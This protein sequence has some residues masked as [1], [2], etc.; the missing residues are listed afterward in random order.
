MAAT[1]K[2]KIRK[3]KAWAII[4]AGGKIIPDA[5]HGLEIVSSRAFARK[6]HKT[7]TEGGETGERV[8]P[9]TITFGH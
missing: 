6:Y 8:I 2:P 5:L 7:R 9:V 3:V 1:R 4:D